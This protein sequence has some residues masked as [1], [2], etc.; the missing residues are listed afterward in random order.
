VD[1]P[2]VDEPP[3][4]GTDVPA[5]VLEPALVPPCSPVAE[6]QHAAKQQAERARSAA[7]A[8]GIRK[9]VSDSH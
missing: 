4:L 5:E 9:G 2:A 3:E 6:R 1:D 7:V 8:R